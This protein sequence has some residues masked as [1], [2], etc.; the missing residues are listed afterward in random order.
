M[1]RTR[2]H[3]ETNLHPIRKLPRNCMKLPKSCVLSMYATHEQ[4]NDSWAWRTRIVAY[5][6]EGDPQLLA[7]DIGSHSHSRLPGAGEVPQNALTGVG[8]TLRSATELP[9]RVLIGYEVDGLALSSPNRTTQQRF[10]DAQLGPSGDPRPAT[11]AS[12]R[13]ST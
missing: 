13:D 10:P 9:P 3:S 12:V 7:L 5:S 2:E 8:T 1:P 4:T 11:T 6:G